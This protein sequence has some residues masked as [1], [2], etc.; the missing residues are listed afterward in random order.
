MP[1]VSVYEPKRKPGLGAQLQFAQRFVICVVSAVAWYRHVYQFDCASDL[2]R[3]AVGN[4]TRSAAL[5]GSTECLWLA[6]P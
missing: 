3:N 5:A 1:S 2:R 4:S 6:S